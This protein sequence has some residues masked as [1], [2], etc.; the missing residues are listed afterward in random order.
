MGTARICRLDNT[1][2]P[3][4]WGS[5]T[6]IP[7]LLGVAPTEEPAAEMWIGAHPGAPSELRHA[8]GD[9][10]GSLLDAIA[11]DPHTLLGDSVVAQ[12]GP[13]LPFLLKLLAA[14]SPLSIQAHPSRAQ[15]IA[16]FGRE[17]DAGIA[18]DAVER[19]YKDANHKPELL[20]ALTDFYG[21]CGFRE[22]ADTARLLDLLAIPQLDAVAQA[23]CDADIRTAVQEIWAVPKTSRGNLVARIVASS[24]RIVASGGEWAELC[25]WIVRIAETHPDDIG[26]VLALLLNLVHLRPGEAIFLA[27][28]QI[29]AYLEGFGVEVMASSDNV[30]RCGLTAKHVAVEELMAVCTF[31][32]ASP[33]RVTP[34]PTLDGQ[35]EYP[36][37]VGDFAFARLEITPASPFERR[38]RGPVIALCTAGRVTV[39]GAGPI[40]E[41]VLDLAPGGAAF[42]A[43]ATPWSASGS[44]TLFVA[45]VGQSPIRSG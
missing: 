14:A 11:D 2:R 20:C 26:V 21:L 28:G 4:A 40:P 44:G 27:A 12:F 17:N 3:Y 38:D 23:L 39:A 30:L 9:L 8:A 6:A 45:S 35:Y 37:P 34:V 22:P 5:F 41:D 15:A 29:H 1:I 13:R 25:S 43:N 42:I 31:T 33:G 36:V 16:G 24:R 18:I 10:A 7:H 19:N 32:P